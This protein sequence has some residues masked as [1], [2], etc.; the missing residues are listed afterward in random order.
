MTA[1]IDLTQLSPNLAL[2]SRLPAGLLRYYQALP[3]AADGGRVT[4]AM[5]YPGNRT[6][7]AM[8]GDL[9]GAEIVP[10]ATSAEAMQ[11]MLAAI[12]PAVGVAQVLLW[13]GRAEGAVPVLP[14]AAA[15]AQVEQARLTELAATAVTARDVL[16]AAEEGNYRLA[17]LALP[18]TT[19]LADLALQANVSFLAVQPA[20]SA[21]RRILVVLRGFAADLTLVQ[22]ATA[23]AANTRA[24]LTL[25]P[26]AADDVFSLGQL[27]NPAVVEGRHLRRCIEV[28]ETLGGAASLRL[29]TGA[30]QQ[31]IAHELAAHA[32]DLLAL[33]AE[34]HGE[35]VATVLR[36]LPAAL[37]PGALLLTKSASRPAA[38]RLRPQTKRRL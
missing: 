26:I 27:L 8:L 11:T 34:G 33:P 24:A 35:F 3:L 21:L 10:V 29:R 38:L 7:I 19:D 31:Q 22:W 16:V 37:A 23:L 20:T 2:V 18:E 12:L 13:S 28:V 36:Q 32:Y 25:L 4:V 9:L 17:V 30:M 15:L 1:W 5:V 14:L 6:A